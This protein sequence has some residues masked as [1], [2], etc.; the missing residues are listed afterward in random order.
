MA[1][2]S[3]MAGTSKAYVTYYIDTSERESFRK[4]G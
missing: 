1:Q 3:D 2:P 4:G